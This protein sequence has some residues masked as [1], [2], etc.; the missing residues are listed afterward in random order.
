MNDDVVRRPAARPLNMSSTKVPKGALPYW[1]A[2]LEA[3]QN[4]QVGLEMATGIDRELIERDLAAATAHREWMMIDILTFGDWLHDE[5]KPPSQRGRPVDPELVFRD[6]RIAAHSLLLE[7]MGWPTKAAVAHVMQLYHVPRTTAFAARKRWIPLL[8]KL[9]Y[10]RAPLQQQEQ[11]LKIF[12]AH[13][14][15]R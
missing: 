3:E 15:S 9:N 1:H 5:P 14:Q 10:D 12:E 8:Q 4:F 2:A 11:R 13:S 6:K 7:L